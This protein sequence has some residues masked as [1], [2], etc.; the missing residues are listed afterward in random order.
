[1]QFGIIDRRLNP[2]GKSLTNRQR[3]VERVKT[4]VRES[5]KKQIAGR[6]IQDKSDAAV[7]VAKKGIEEP[8]FIYG[9]D[10]GTW[11]HIFPGNKEY[12][13]GDNLPRP[14]GGG[15][16]GGSEGSPDGDG[17]DDF[18][19]NISYEEYVDAI[20]EDLYLPDMIKR[21]DK[22]TISFTRHRAGYTTVGSASNLALERTMIH[23]IARRMALKTPK[24]NRI[25]ELFAELLETDEEDRRLAIT[26]EINELQRSADSINFLEKSDLRYVNYDRQPNPITKALMI[27]IMDVSGSVTQVMKDLSK[28]FYLL[29]WLFLTRQYKHVDIVF[30]RHTHIA[31]EVDQ[32]TFFHGTE[33]GG[34]VVSTAYEQARRI[35]KERYNIDHWNIYMSQCSDGDNTSSDNSVAEE[36]LSLMLPW[37]QYVTYVE[38][39]HMR[40]DAMS[41]IKSD[42]KSEIW[43]M[44]EKL[45]T[46]APKVAARHLNNPDEVIEVFRSLFQKSV[47]AA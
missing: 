10:A 3:F 30:I 41:Y 1:M 22:Q 24:L 14:P 7:T 6:S 23:G 46:T 34:T 37:F 32:E 43:T 5:A 16:G 29:M 13:V 40:N 45:S 27:L 4:A 25:E 21:S 38:V 39:G 26:E 17:N 18:T 19:F 28:R 35:I 31:D 15:S 47:V 33:T 20:L 12:M 11:D 9:K 8:Q 42:R 44:F 2:H 36:L